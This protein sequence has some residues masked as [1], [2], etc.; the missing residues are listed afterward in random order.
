MLVAFLAQA[1]AVGGNFLYCRLTAAAP[2]RARQTSRR[3]TTR[4]LGEEG[5][6]GP[7]ETS[8]EEKKGS[9]KAAPGGAWHGIAAPTPRCGARVAVQSPTPARQ[10]FSTVTSAGK[11]SCTSFIVSFRTTVTSTSKNKLHITCRLTSEYSAPL[12]RLLRGNLGP[13]HHFRLVAERALPDPRQ[14]RCLLRWLAQVRRRHRPSHSKVSGW[15]Y[16]H[17]TVSQRS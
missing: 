15:K 5:P 4:V 9:S 16:R 12:I 11:T 13:R 2:L 17:G 3:R 10:A 7:S 6:H 14:E 8:R 1:A